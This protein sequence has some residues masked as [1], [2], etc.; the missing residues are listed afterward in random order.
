M[1]TR[2]EVE[3]LCK[4]SLTSVAVTHSD[5]PSSGARYQDV[6]IDQTQVSFPALELLLYTCVRTVLAVTSR[7]LMS[8]KLCDAR[9]LVFF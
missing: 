2:V 7:Y 6:D 1:K 5:S 9:S 8:F 3:M 4:M